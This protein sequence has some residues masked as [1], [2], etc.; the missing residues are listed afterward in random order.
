[1]RGA[2]IGDVPLVEDEDLVIVNDRRQSMRDGENRAVRELFLDF[3][4]Y[5]RIGL[6]IHISRGLI[7]HDYLGLSQDGPGQAEELLL[8]HRKGRLFE[9]DFVVELAVKLL[10]LF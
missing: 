5:E 8:P 6:K 4:L 10:D 1:M 2:A 9:G 7:K 3:L